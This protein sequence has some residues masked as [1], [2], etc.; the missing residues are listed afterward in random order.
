M[1]LID[2]WLQMPIAHCVIIL[3]SVRLTTLLEVQHSPLHIY[4]INSCWCQVPNHTWKQQTFGIAYTLVCLLHMH[5][6]PTFK[7]EAFHLV[8][9]LQ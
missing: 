5:D 6:M 7:S 2:T 9:K 1:H 3:H 4:I 8:S